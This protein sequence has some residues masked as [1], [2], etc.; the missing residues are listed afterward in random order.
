MGRKLGIYLSD[1]P[2]LKPESKSHAFVT[3]LFSK[4]IKPRQIARQRS[5]RTFSSCRNVKLT[6]INIL[7]VGRITISLAHLNIRKI[8]TR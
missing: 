1:I 6:S 7:L 8:L 4:Q 3:L 2:L 5:L